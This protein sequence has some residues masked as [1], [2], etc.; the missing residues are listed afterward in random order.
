MTSPN[1][2]EDSNPLFK[3]YAK[4]NLSIDRL[5]DRIAKQMRQE[6][7]RLANL[8]V[9][10]PFSRLSLLAGGGTD[11]QDFGGPQN[12][13]VW[14]VR[15][16]GA[17]PSPLGA[18]AAVVTW[19]VGQPMPG[20]AAGQLPATLARWQFTTVPA[21]Q[22]FTSDVIKVLPGEHL[23]AGITGAPANSSLALT[24]SVNDQPQFAGA[25]VTIE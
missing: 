9:N 25:P 23:I 3:L 19:Y 8:P 14:F 10:V 5:G 1:E 20:P 11:I 12:G 7:Q 2:D 6:Q 24:V 22:T 21:F 13:R 15:L 16:L 17:L 4:L 18:N